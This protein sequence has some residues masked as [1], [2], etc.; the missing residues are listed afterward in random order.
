MRDHREADRRPSPVLSRPEGG[1]DALGQPWH[2][3]T[4]PSRPNS[5]G[6]GAPHF[7]RGW[8]DRVADP[9]G[10]RGSD[11]ASASP[12]HSRRR[13]SMDGEG[14]ERRV[15]E[16][17]RRRGDDPR[18]PPALRIRCSASPSRFRLR[19][20]RERRE[21]RGESR[22]T[23]GNPSAS[24][25]ALHPR[26]PSSP[27]RPSCPWNRPPREASDHRVRWPAPEAGKPPTAERGERPPC[28][29]ARFRSRAAAA[30][31]ATRATM[32]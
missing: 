23:T 22:R 1:A 25:A 29:V 19:L 11:R 7:A 16:E 27:S 18:Q 5:G 9:M 14:G 12:T 30:P 31:R 8:R 2:R 32:A 10:R 6:D 20:K 24:G 15:E 17:R 4:P 28:E 13:R 3:P 26:G 21:E